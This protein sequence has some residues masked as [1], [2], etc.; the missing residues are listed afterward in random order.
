M[1]I[2]D[3][4]GEFAL[5]ERLSHIVPSRHP[6]VLVGIGD[7]AAV[8]RIND[9]QDPYMLVTTD[10]LVAKDHFNT[11]WATPE[12]IGM[13]TVECNVSDIAAMGGV[14]TFMF[15]SLVLTPETTIEWTENLYRGM[16]DSCRRHNVITAGGDTTHGDVET[17]S[18]TLLGRVSPENLCLRSHAKPGDWIAVTGRLGASTA[19]LNL[20]QKNL[21]VSSYLLDKHLTPRCRLDASQQLA[22]I[23]NAM[24][25]ISDGLASEVNHVCRQ[26][27]VGAEVFAKDIPLHP[28]VID[29]GRVLG[30][31]P[32]DFALS[33]GEDFELLFTIS[34]EDLYK[35]KQ[36]GLKYFTVGRITDR[37]EG[38]FLITESEARVP[39]KGGYNHFK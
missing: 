31:S 2:K 16:A 7:D 32:I 29:A 22:S 26:S 4:G 23:V 14:P 19:G 9:G 1:F 12:Q 15:V 21:P 38:T 34:P 20:L 24:I 13:K 17:I 39:L 11:R 3:V 18:I 33:G 35:L 6:E 28:D 8:I 36:T 10:T 27:G 30:I 25:D 5:I 37:G